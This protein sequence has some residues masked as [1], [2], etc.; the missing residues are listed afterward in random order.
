MQKI[1][2]YFDKKK[3]IFIFKKYKKLAK[4]VIHKST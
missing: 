1:L 4:I 2:I 3:I